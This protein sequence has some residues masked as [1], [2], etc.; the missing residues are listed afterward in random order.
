MYKKFFHI[1][2]MSIEVQSD[3]PFSATTFSPKF[4]AFEI[5]TPLEENIVLRHRF[6]ECR[7]T[8]RSE[9]RVYLKPPWAI[10]HQD[11]QW[12]YQWVKAE[13]PHENYFRTV[14]TDKEHS[15]LDVYN[16]S[17]IKEQFLKGGLTS[18]TMFPTDQILM[19]R[20]LAYRNGCIMHSLGV[21][22]DNQGLLFVGHS[23]A[24]KSTM[25][26]IMKQGAEILCDDRNIIRK[27]DNAY[28]VSG[29]WSHGDV[30]DVSPA[31]LPLKGIFFLEKADTN[32]VSPVT[33]SRYAFE[34]LLA[35]MIRPFETRDWWDNAL[36][37]LSGLCQQ[38]PCWNLQ[39]DKSGQAYDLIKGM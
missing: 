3:L 20:I 32:L 26:G 10:Y 11:D 28:F 19:G 18:L 13:P 30:P 21:S 6:E 37:F 9:N 25:A 14:V 27:K 8:A 33:D 15:F 2:N 22:L 36:D 39:F 1:A 17:S 29:T 7:T 35:C 12:I 23:D 4:K 38:V 16:D 31:T 34:R 5:N 24:G